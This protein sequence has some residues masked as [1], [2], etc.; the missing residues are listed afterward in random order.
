VPSLKKI[1]LIGSTGSIGRSTLDVIA[2]HPDR[3]RV[4]V[5]AAHSNVELLS[6]Q[7]RQFRPSIVAVADASKESELRGLLKSESVSIVCGEEE[8]IKLAGL[9]EIETV[10][11]AIVGAAGL[12]TS[13]EALRN[14][15]SLA[16]ANKESLVAGGPL[17]A[18]MVERHGGMILPIDSEHSAVWQCLMAGRKS[19]VRRIILTASG[20]P[21]RTL[22]LDQ[23][24]TIT[25]EQA[26]NHPTWKMGNKITIDSATLANKGLEVIEAAA[27]FGI[28]AD[29][30]SVVI[31][32]QSIVHSMVEFVDSSIMAQMSKP[33]MRLPINFAL[34][35]P[36]R[37]ESDFGRLEMSELSKLTFEPPDYAKFPAL[38]LAFEAAK[39]G[40]TAPAVY[41]AANEI[42]VQAFV[43]HSIQFTQIA[44]CIEHAL[45]KVAVVAN[46]GLEQILEADRMAREV[47]TEMTGTYTIC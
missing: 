20:G 29:S 2:S 37:V 13:L 3:L 46:P 30:V 40:G 35:W 12:R 5:L 28:P 16:L 18:P 6:Q 11:N 24:G 31:H 26:L 43:A 42:A 1:A 15:K 14:G 22:P 32:P 44:N 10:V 34:F 39:A 27:L 8:I 33:D 25:L 23:F 19:E 17:F 4:E 45:T 38:R 47:V 41:N 9:S 36:E 21:F 7:F